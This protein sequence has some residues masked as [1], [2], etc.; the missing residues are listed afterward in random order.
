MERREDL[1]VGDKVTIQRDFSNK[2]VFSTVKKI[3]TKK[4]TARWNHGK[5]EP[6]YLI[7]EDDSKWKV[8]DGKPWGEKYASSYVRPFR[9]SDIEQNAA[10]EASEELYEA[11]KSDLPDDVLRKTVENL[12]P[13]LD[14]KKIFQLLYQEYRP[15]QYYNLKQIEPLQ[16][17]LDYYRRKQLDKTTSA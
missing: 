17:I 10:H 13:E 6:V 5:E 3:G 2:F 15:I 11:L 14:V 8:S 9:D 1:Q 16:P 7:L 12:I 4:S